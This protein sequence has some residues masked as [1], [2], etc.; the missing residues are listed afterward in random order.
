L[1]LN[2]NLL[3]S[4]LNL[5]KLNQI[6][7][8]VRNPIPCP[9]PKLRWC[10]WCLLI[11]LGIWQV[12]SCK[13]IFFMI[14]KLLSVFVCLFYYL[15]WHLVCIFS[16]SQIYPNQDSWYPNINNEVRTSNIKRCL[17]M[18]G[19]GTSFTI[20]ICYSVTVHLIFLVLMF[21]RVWEY[22][23][24]SLTKNYL[25]IWIYWHTYW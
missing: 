22:E 6:L 19:F 10:Q 9:R 24:G 18:I 7:M 1:N 16:N 23:A 15:H 25:E 2:S 14:L 12:P 17:I 11:C 13:H 3:V 8:R 21:C 20:C 4:G 5:D